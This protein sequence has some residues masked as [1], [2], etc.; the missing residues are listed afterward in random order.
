MVSIENQSYARKE[1]NNE[2]TNLSDTVVD[3]CG[4]CRYGAF[5]WD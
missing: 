5:G 2:K 3:V 4:F 1:R